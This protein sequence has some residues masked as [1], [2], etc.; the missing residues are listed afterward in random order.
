MSDAV[1]PLS[2]RE[3]KRTFVQGDRRLEVLRGVSLDLRPGEIVALLVMMFLCRRLGRTS[4]GDRVLG[5]LRITQTPLEAT[6]RSDSAHLEPSDVA[7][8]VGLFG[9][10][11]LADPALASLGTVLH[12]P[13]GAGGSCSSGCGSGSSCS[14]GGCSSGCGGGCGGCGS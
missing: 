2:L 3:I 12:P 4:W 10:A 1:L 14:G 8:A 9:V 5:D 6:V 7:L 13:P 11:V